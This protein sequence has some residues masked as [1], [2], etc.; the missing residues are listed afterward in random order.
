MLHSPYIEMTP[1]EVEV[2]A[3][4]IWRLR[5]GGTSVDTRRAV[6]SDVSLMLRADYAASYVW[7]ESSGS[8]TQRVAQNIDGCR[9]LA[10]DEYFHSI[11]PVTP[12]LRSLRSAACVDDVL[13]RTFLENHEY[14]ADFLKPSG[15]HHGVNVYFF[16]AGRDV[17]DLRIWRGADEPAFTQRDVH[18]LNALTPYF[19][20]ALANCSA[21]AIALTPRERALVSLLADGCSDKEIARRMEIAFTTVRTHLN[22]AMIK[23]EC[24]NRTEL[25]IRG[26]RLL[27][28][29]ARSAQY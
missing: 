24:G 8:S 29:R 28:E 27:Q 25:A 16:N 19:E 4:V 18:L 12:A 23:L 1:A 10:Y 3:R 11:D 21:G 15:M 22:N 9:L 20:N 17:G 13:Q 14:Y 5:D 7:D 2:F 6:L 26:T